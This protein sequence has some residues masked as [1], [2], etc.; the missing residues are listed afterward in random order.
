MTTTCSHV[1]FG[2]T[3]LKHWRVSFRVSV[4]TDPLAIPTW[5]V[6]RGTSDSWIMRSGHSSQTFPIHNFH[7]PLV[8]RHRPLPHPRPRPLPLDGL[9]VTWAQLLVL[10][11]S[12]LQL[13]LL[14]PNRIL[15]AMRLI[16]RY[17]LLEIV[18]ITLLVPSPSLSSF[19]F[20]SWFCCQS[21]PRTQWARRLPVLL[22][23]AARYRRAA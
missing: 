17:S 21:R 13:D 23:G 8:F 11:A 12:P 7:S 15:R 20:G 16:C 3:T 18:R 4:V 22:E 9:C 2:L 14:D 10:P 6:L 5:C 19:S 1:A